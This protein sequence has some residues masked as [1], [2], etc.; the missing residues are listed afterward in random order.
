MAERGGLVGQRQETRAEFKAIAHE[1]VP[2]TTAEG[3]DFLYLGSGLVKGIGPILAKKLVG[4]LEPD[5]LVVIESRSFD[6]NRSMGSAQ[7][8][9]RIAHAWQEAKQVRE[10]DAV[11][12]QPRREHQPCGANLQDLRRAG[13][14]E[15]AEQSLHAGEG[16]LRDRLRDRRPDRPEGR[17]S[18]DSLNRAR[19]GIDHVLLEA[20]SDGHCALPL[21]KLKVAAVKLLEVLEGDSRAGVVAD[22]HEWLPA[23]GGDRR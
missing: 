12:A 15:G 8:R 11:P 2:P 22:V 14:R 20:T 3:I 16:H 17:D 21:A 7:R 6:S 1:T 13:N 18:S 19:A 5:I 4:R 9:E 10:I 23:A